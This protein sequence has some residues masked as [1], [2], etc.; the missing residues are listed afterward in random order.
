MTD[1][2]PFQPKRDPPLTGGARFIRGFTRIGMAI[3][4][5]VT[6]VGVPT[7]LIGAINNYNYAADNHRT[8]QCI[9]RQARSGYPFKKKYEY[10]S[11]IDFGAGGCTPAYSFEYMT[12]SEVTAIADAP[13][14]TFLTSN[15]PSTLGSGL[16]I[17]GGL[18]IIAYVAFWV[19]GW[20]FAGFTRDA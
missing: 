18:A 5:L 13:A 1:I 4:V 2:R 15:G 14:P 20:L 12:I 9:A 11:A 19:I 10:S 17:T 16:M 8:A 6:L 7:S 3:A